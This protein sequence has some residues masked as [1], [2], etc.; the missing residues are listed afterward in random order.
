MAQPIVASAGSLAQ[1]TCTVRQMQMIATEDDA[2]MAR[3]SVA[4][5]SFIPSCE[6]VSKKGTD[7]RRGSGRAFPLTERRT[8]FQVPFGPP[9]VN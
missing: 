7:G 3:G 9:A 6:I 5:S 1:Q 4:T 8:R 2:A